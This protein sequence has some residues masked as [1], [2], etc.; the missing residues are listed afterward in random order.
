MTRNHLPLSFNM[1]RS[2]S[3]LITKAENDS[4]EGRA[5][6][7]D[8]TR[9]SDFRKRCLKEH[10]LSSIKCAVMRLRN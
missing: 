5:Q 10:K 1:S 4:N 3:I 6:I 8:R 9:E 2:N 7:R